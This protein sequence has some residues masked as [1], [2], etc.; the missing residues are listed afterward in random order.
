MPF[1]ACCCAISSCIFDWPDCLGLVCEGTVL[2]FE[3]N[4]KACRVSQIQGKCCICLE[5][6]CYCKSPTTCIKCVKQVCCLDIR[7]AFPCEKEV[8]IIII[9]I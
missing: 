9:I 2:C 8:L 5:A 6:D 7:C 4:F 3:G 1:S